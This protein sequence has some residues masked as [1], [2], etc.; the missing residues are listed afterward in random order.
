MAEAVYSAAHI[1]VLPA[2]AWLTYD[3]EEDRLEVGSY[4]EW[5]GECRE[6]ADSDRATIERGHVL[7]VHLEGMHL[8]V[9]PAVGV[10]AEAHAPRRPH[11]ARA[12]GAPAR[13]AR[14]LQPRDRGDPRRLAEDGGAPHRAHLREGRRLHARHG[15]R[16]RLVGVAERR[17][18]RWWADAEEEVRARSTRDPSG[19]LEALD[20][21][22]A[23]TVLVSVGVLTLGIALGLASLAVDGGSFDAAM[24]ATLAA[25]I[26]YAG[27]AVLRRRGLHGRRS[28]RFVLASFLL[29]VLV[30]SVTH[31]A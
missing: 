1:Q 12:R 6:S 20:R 17:A 26:V 14:S 23:R 3:A 8:L 13:R 18:G 19:W 11:R 27:F 5:P 25:W 15:T 9:A 30:L 7:P 22:V 2:A 28:A 16:V 21:V 4:R 31:F 29:V 10:V 24:A